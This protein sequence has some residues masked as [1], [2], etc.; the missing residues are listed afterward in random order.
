MSIVIEES[1]F[2]FLIIFYDQEMYRTYSRNISV[3][4]FDCEKR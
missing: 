1:D 3:L 4:N 2:F